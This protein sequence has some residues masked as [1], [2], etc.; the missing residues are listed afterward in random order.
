MTKKDFEIV[1]GKLGIKFSYKEFDALYRSQ[2]TDKHNDVI[3]KD[4]LK[5]LE[6]D[7]IRD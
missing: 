3:Y 1:L 6:R 7:G 4:F 2:N 5:K